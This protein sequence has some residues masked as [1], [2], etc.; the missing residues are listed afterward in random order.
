VLS[1]STRD[2]ERVNTGEDE[3][4]H[5]EVNEDQQGKVEQLRLHVP[6]ESHKRRL[7]HEALA[8]LGIPLKG[9]E[10]GSL[11]GCPSV[12]LHFGLKNSQ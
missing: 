1:K 8:V 2:R 12:A 7:Y 5:A 10:G 11:P 9:H 4:Q 3:E 6:S